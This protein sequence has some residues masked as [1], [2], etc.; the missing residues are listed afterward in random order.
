M[1]FKAIECTIEFLPKHL[2]LTHDDGS[3]WYHKLDGIFDCICI[4]K[5]D[6][7][8]IHFYLKEVSV[9]TLKFKKQHTLNEF[10]QEVLIRL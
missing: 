1:K 6:E 9:F 3:I 5:N 8:T 2:K 4:T 7:P 10:V